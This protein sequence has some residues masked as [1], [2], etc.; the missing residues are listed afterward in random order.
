[1]TSFTITESVVEK[2]TLGWL[3]GLGWSVAHGPD[4]TTDTLNAERTGY[5]QVVLEQRLRDALTRLNPGSS[6]GSARR[7]LSPDWPT[8]KGRHWKPEIGPSI[9]CSWMESRWSTGPIRRC[10]SW[11]TGSVCS[12]SRIRTTTTGLPLI[13]SPWSKTSTNAA[14]TSFCSSTACRSG[15]IELKNPA[16]EKA[17]IWTAWQQIQT[18][19]AELPTLFSM[20]A[21]LI[22]SDGVEARIGTLTAGQGVVQALADD[23]RVRS[24]ADPHMTRACR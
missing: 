13:N 6:R 16:D 18:Y 1:M 5:G 3:E 14:L 23:L 22:V 10:S 19:K 17:T 12:I 7:C 9:A 20:N 24:L 11:G 4:I 15:V 21:A 8:Q 2:A